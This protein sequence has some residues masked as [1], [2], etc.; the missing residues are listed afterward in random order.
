MNIFSY[1]RQQREFYENNSIPLFDGAEFSQYDTINKIDNYW[2]DQ[3]VDSEMAHDDIIGDYPF[4]NISKFRVLLEARATDFDTKHVEVSPKNGSRKARISAMIATKALQQ[5]MEDINFGKFINDTCYMRPKYGAVLATKVDE[6][7]VTLPW[8]N[9]IT[10]QTDIMSG[11]RIVRHYLTPSQMSKKRDIWENVD[12]ALLMAQEMREKGSYASSEAETQGDIIEVSEV[13]GD[14]TKSQLDEMIAQMKGEDY[15]YNPEDDTKYVSARIFVC[16][17]DWN[18]EMEID[19]TTKEKIEVENGVVLYAREE[20]TT[21]KLIRRNPIAGRG[22]GEGLVE[23]LFEHQKW[24]NFSKTEE[25]RM[26]A[27]AGKKVYVTD[28][29]DVLTNIYDEGID[30]GTVLRVGEGKSITSLNQIPTGLPVY[31]GMRQELDESA[32]RQTSSFG[33]K[34]GEEAKAGTPFRSQYL[35][36]VEASSQFEQY[37]E[38]MAIEYF[39]PIIREWVLPDALKKATKEDEIYDMFS[40]QELQLID[41]VIIDSTVV[42]EVF[43]RTMKR[44]QVTPE[45]IEQIK[46]DTK[47][48]LERQGKKRTIKGIKDFIKEAGD[49]VIIRTSDESRNKAVFFESM[50]N[51]LQLLAP[52]DPRRNAIIDR[53]L[54]SIGITKEELSLYNEEAQIMTQATPSQPRLENKQLLRSTQTGANLIPNS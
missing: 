42:K 35:Q 30:H 15:D 13:Q 28:D 3:Y 48:Q 9:L 12:E 24:H 40:P 19:D 26:V 45:L 8:Q 7:V 50:S 52:E 33:A 31:Q 44:E 21:H 37:R 11:I 20:E 16:G 10:D 17:V 46:L 54:G 18:E 2:I 5:H 47:R 49:H 38:E 1:I 43:E 39:S 51:T 41:E 36:N 23:S 32:S 25:M 14:I 34:L 53:I 29:P 27:I 22:L 6:E 4:D